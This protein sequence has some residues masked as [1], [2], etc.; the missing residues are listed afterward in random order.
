MWQSEH[1]GD[2]KHRAYE[3]ARKMGKRTPLDVVL[4]TS[5]FGAWYCEVYILLSSSRN[6]NG[7]IPVSEIG[8][9]IHTNTL[10]DEAAVFMKTILLIDRILHQFNKDFEDGRQSNSN[11]I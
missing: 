8:S 9:Y 4:T 2:T 7:F 1:G 3:M 5:E 10:I 6:M 11:K